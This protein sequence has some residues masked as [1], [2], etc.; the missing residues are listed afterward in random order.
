MSICWSTRFHHL[1]FLCLML[2]RLSRCA[3]LSGKTSIFMKGSAS[4]G[5]VSCEFLYSKAEA[6]DFGGL[7]PFF[8][9]GQIRQPAKCYHGSFIEESGGFLPTSCDCWDGWRG[10]F[11]NKGIC[12]LFGLYTELPFIGQSYHSPTRFFGHGLSTFQITPTMGKSTIVRMNDR[13]FQELKDV[14]H[15]EKAFVFLGPSQGGPGC[16]WGLESYPPPQVGSIRFIKVLLSPGFMVSEESISGDPVHLSSGSAVG[17]GSLYSNICMVDSPWGP[18]VITPIRIVQSECSLQSA[19][20]LNSFATANHPMG[21]M[22]YTSIVFSYKDSGNIHGRVFATPGNVFFW[23]VLRYDGSWESKGVHSTT[24]TPQ[25][26]DYSIGWAF[27]WDTLYG[28]DFIRRIVRK[29]V[30][31]NLDLISPTTS[32]IPLHDGLTEPLAEAAKIGIVNGKFL[33]FVPVSQMVFEV[34]VC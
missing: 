29:F 1:I 17:H 8:P 12:K 5:D 14:L 2:I 28:V 27:E 18:Q 22:T 20:I 33:L 25:G 19:T 9:W 34:H 31:S 10:T 30:F 32:I 3:I 4:M 15:E 23:E 26:G 7:Y 16:I 11:C 13:G 24:F 21:G 6:N